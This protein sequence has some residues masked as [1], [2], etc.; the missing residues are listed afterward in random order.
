[1]VGLLQ[2]TTIG[3]KL[4]LQT[5]TLLAS[6][7]TS[8]KLP[9]QTVT[10]WLPRTGSRVFFW[11]WI[12]FWIRYRHH[13]HSVKIYGFICDTSPIV[14]I[15][16]LISGNSFWIMASPPWLGASIQ[17]FVIGY[18]ARLPPYRVR[19]NTL[20]LSGCGLGQKCN[21][22]TSVWSAQKAWNH[23]CLRLVMPVGMVAPAGDV[24]H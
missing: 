21:P 23:P 6:E 8:N 1:M 15:K 13:R 19:K 18:R 4:Q 7:D 9:L 22:L 11:I 14:T 10:F 12:I 16:F 2:H 3:N 17:Y 24:W 5:A 20:K